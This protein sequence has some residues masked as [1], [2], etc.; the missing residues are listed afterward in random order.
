MR[1]YRYM[2]DFGG[3]DVSRPEV[4][5]TMDDGVNRIIYQ[6]WVRKLESEVE[7]WGVAVDNVEGFDSEGASYRVLYLQEHTSTSL[8]DVFRNLGG[9]GISVSGGLAISVEK[10]VHLSLDEAEVITSFD[11]LDG[12]ME[13]VG[14]Q[15]D[16]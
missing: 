1:V 13:Y 11:T 8:V 4:T 14:S 3:W 7:C 12:A 6:V 10:D 2:S 15:V 16:G 9:V 5:Y